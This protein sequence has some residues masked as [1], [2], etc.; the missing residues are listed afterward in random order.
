MRLRPRQIFS[1]LVPTL[2]ISTGLGVA[3][4]AATERS[5]SPRE[6]D[7]TVFT[8]PTSIGPYD[9]PNEKS[10]EPSTANLS[11][12]FVQARDSHATLSEDED[13]VLIVVAPGIISEQL[14]GYDQEIGVT[15]EVVTFPG[16]I[17]CDDSASASASASVSCSSYET[18]ESREVR[19]IG[20]RGCIEP[21]DEPFGGEGETLRVYLANDPLS[22]DIWENDSVKR[23]YVSQP[24]VD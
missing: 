17:I 19:Q 1:G 18:Y 3:Y 2:F 21:C 7:A 15:L 9:I 23:V 8:P 11:S 16:E 12:N 10:L 14:G 13:E 4:F 22:Q 6:L 5:P 24:I 20:Q